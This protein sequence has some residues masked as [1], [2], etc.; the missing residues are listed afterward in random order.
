MYRLL[1]VDDEE[2]IVNSLFE[3]FSNLNDEELDVYKAYS[4]EEAIE[5]LIRTRID[6]VISDIRMPEIDGL[7][8]LEEIQ[9][10]WPYCKV[11]FLTGYD[12]FEYIYHAVQIA[13]VAYI[14][15][16]EDPDKVVHAVLEAII[17]IK[18]EDE[19]Q[20]YL[21][22]AKEQMNKAKS[23]F[24]KDYLLGLVSGRERRAA[25][26]KQ[27][28]DMRIPLS[29]DWPV[30]YVV[31]HAM[32]QNDAMS[33][34]ETTKHFLSI[35]KLI[36]QKIWMKCRN[37]VVIDSDHN[38][39]IF[40]QP[41]DKEL[42]NKQMI[43]DEAYNK[44]IAYLK[45]TLELVQ[46]SCLEQLSTTM[47]FIISDKPCQ[48]NMLPDIDGAMKEILSEMDMD[49]M[50][51]VF[52]VEDY[53]KN[54]YDPQI[55]SSE[56][57]GDYDNCYRNMEFEWM[58]ALLNKGDEVLYFEK[59]ERVTEPLM[60]ISGKHD[61]LALEIYFNCALQL[62]NFINHR[63]LYGALAFRIGQ[64]RLMRISEHD[65]WEQARHYL[66]EIS[67]HIFKIRVENVLNKEEKMVKKIQ[68]FIQS[69][70]GSDLSL[71][72]LAEE[73]YMNPS[74]LSRFYKRAT[75]ENISEFID[76]QRILAAKEMMRQGYVKI[77]EIG[78]R[79]G[80][81]N[82]GSFTRFFKKM[83]H[84]TPQEYMDNIVFDRTPE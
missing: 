26:K 64:N 76:A 46:L 41:L 22:E 73:V 33:Y 42:E 72:R 45:G 19:I 17:S 36:E 66:F 55:V 60:K 21:Y 58:S 38:L 52:T 25:T 34:L 1:I 9:K 14:L 48:W 84:L 8:L 47:C 83:T 62:L 37:L 50:D 54:A 57:E 82:P 78:K 59:L 68:T 7:H 43:E 63:G 2:I 4:G 77:Y 20:T 18:Q 51:A 70:L 39:H 44:I 27:F 23:L 24:Q 75:G 6:I 11:I 61:P 67:R 32:N 29:P 28:D 81:D 74:Y 12:S 40:I 15:K 69:D 71:V 79:V 5:W 16:S 31:G 49:H 35:R 3:M 10:R 53:W 65:N 56:H 80:Y 13:D 30:L